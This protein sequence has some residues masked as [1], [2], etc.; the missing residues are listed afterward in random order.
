M[1][2]RERA[3]EH[4]TSAQLYA[5]EQAARAE[6]SAEMARVVRAVFARVKGV[7]HA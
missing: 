1:K 7:F 4:P 5:L 3:L 2:N 6:R